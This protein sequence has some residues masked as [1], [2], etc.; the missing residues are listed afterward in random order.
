MADKS[1]L[2][3]GGGGLVGLQ[4]ARRIAYT[5]DPDLIVIAALTEQEAHE[6]VSN[7]QSMFTDSDVRFESAWGNIFVRSALTHASRRELLAEDDNRQA[8][9][10]DLF[11]RSATAYEQSRLVQL[12]HQY[13][14]DVIIDAI[15][16]AT[17]I[18]YQDTYT[19]SRNAKR[20]FDRLLTT[21]DDDAPSATA[22]AEAELALET[23]L[24][25]QAIPQLVRHVTMLHQAMCAVGTRLYLKI[26][27]TG[28]G[29]MG[30][31][32]PYTHGED[33]PS[34]TLMSKTAVAFAHTGLL[35]L[36]AR[37]VDGPIVKEIKP[38]A[39]IGY[40]D[41]AS[42][43]INEHGQPV[44]RYSSRTD[45]LQDILEIR[46]ERNGFEAFGPLE[47]PVVDTGENGLFTR[48]EFEAITSLRQMEFITPEEIARETVLEIRGGN[49]G[50]DVIA[51]I[52]SSVLDPTYRAGYLRQQAIDEL[53]N[54]ERETGTHS[55]AWGQLGPPQLSKL[56]W[57]AELLRLAYG[58]L[59]A[60]VSDSAESI[61]AHLYARI[62]NDANLRRTITSVGVP[63]LCPDGQ[64]LIRGPFI[65]IPEVPETDICTVPIAEGDVDAWAKK[66]WV[67][68]RPENLTV[69]QERFR[70]MEAFRKR[71]RMKGSAAITRSGYLYDNIRP[72]SIVG[73][74]FNTEEG[75]YRI[76]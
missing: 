51:A 75:G 48:G 47:L 40:A 22:S 62:E 2:I 31:N 53:I 18:S 56:L 50:A 49:T 6:A 37:T 76:K 41:I 30:L 60:V 1:F 5:L 21:L 16:T 9:Y 34:A 11:G 7:L 17:A 73:W 29:G 54:L 8:L 14:P 43:T 70:R 57:E 39:M 26:G 44:N 61:A 15:N 24:I 25:S 45:Y 72:G 20:H 36:M 67:D 33:K 27:T 42:R 52:D 58:T 68:L 35:F 59:K 64:Q 10:D 74:I 63:I 19:A 4:I 32:I 38:G 23:V 69:W 12:V 65:R 28:T 66:G 3:L 13:R 71:M 46:S 55:I